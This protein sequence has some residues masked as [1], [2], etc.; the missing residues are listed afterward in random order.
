MCVAKNFVP[1][2][3]SMQRRHL[4]SHTDSLH[5]NGALCSCRAQQLAQF[6]CWR[7]RSKPPTKINVRQVPV[8]SLATKPS[9][10][11]SSQLM[12][13]VTCDLHMLAGQ[14]EMCRLHAMLRQPEA[15]AH[16]T[17]QAAQENAASL[18]EAAPG[19]PAAASLLPGA[20]AWLPGVTREVEL[21][22]RA[23]AG[24][25]GGTSTTELR[26]PNRGK[27]VRLPLLAE[28]RA[29]SCCSHG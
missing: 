25:A 5:R 24:A 29:A 21:M 8:Q 18:P 26:V 16:V 27:V 7:P 1:S 22:T 3:T 15:A 23:G 2:C 4:K 17:P 28:L 13:G 11:A 20:A 14:A 12:D 6:K 10:K 19:R 9:G